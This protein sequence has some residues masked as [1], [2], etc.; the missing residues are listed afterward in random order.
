M[1]WHGAQPSHASPPIGLPFPPIMQSWFDTPA[2]KSCLWK[3]RRWEERSV[4]PPVSVPLSRLSRLELVGLALLAGGVAWTLVVGFWRD[5]NPWPL[6]G[7]LIGSVAALLLADRVSRR[8]G[9]AVPLGLALLPFVAAVVA[10]QSLL[11][12]W[13]LGYANASGALYLIAAAAAVMFGLRATT[14]RGRRAAAVLAAFWAVLVLLVNAQTAAVF[15]GLLAVGLFVRSARAVRVAV[16]AGGAATLLTLAGAIALGLGYVRWLRTDVLFHAVDST[17]GQVRV[18]LWHDALEQIT[19][20]PIVG[21]GPGQ[22]RADSVALDDWAATVHNEVLQVTA[23]TGLIG[24]VLV[25]ALL[26]W[27]FVLLWSAPLDGSALP[28]VIALTGIAVQHRLHV[29]LPAGADRGCRAGRIRTG[30]PVACRPAAD[31]DRPAA[32]SSVHDRRVRRRAHSDAALAR[33]KP[34]PALHRA[35]RR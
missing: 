20:R 14:G 25:L 8:S 15:A 11:D 34:Q 18:A 5:A 28:A 13:A 19:A 32:S 6:V 30:L 31:T 29:A 17:L 10:R 22:F 12:R 16:V 35:E 3:S 21:V 9:L 2:S 24:G 23:E 4:A 1:L 27:V 7:I 26:A 33:R